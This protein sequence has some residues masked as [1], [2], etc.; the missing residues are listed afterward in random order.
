MLVERRQEAEVTHSGI[1]GA[2]VHTTLAVL[3]ILLK[4]SDILLH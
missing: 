1:Q 3:A 2:I 4:N